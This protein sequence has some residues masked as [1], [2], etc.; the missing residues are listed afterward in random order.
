MCLQAL[1]L[2]NDP[3]F[4][5]AARVLAEKVLQEKTKI[6]EQLL[7][8]Y[9]QLTGLTPNAKVIQLLEQHYEEQKVHFK[10]HPE[11]AKKLLTIGYSPVKVGQ[12]PTD[13]SAMTVVCNTIMSFDETIMKR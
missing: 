1:S 5:E 4:V 8:A 3:Q 10:D 13:V 7:L 9:R 6:N 12:S 2:L 11:L